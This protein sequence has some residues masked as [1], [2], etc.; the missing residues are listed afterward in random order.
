MIDNSIAFEHRKPQSLDPSHCLAHS[1]WDIWMAPLID[2]FTW[3]QT[4]QE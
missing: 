2:L 3:I 1:L 4:P